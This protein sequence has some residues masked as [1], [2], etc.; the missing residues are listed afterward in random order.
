VLDNA[1]IDFTRTFYSHLF[2]GTP[3]C[4]AFKQAKGAVEFIY[5][6]TEASL[7]LMLLNEDLYGDETLDKTD[8]GHDCYSLPVSAPGVWKCHSEH[9]RIK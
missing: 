9:N 2:K 4:E 7:F 6:K 8:I 5:K 1:A 3:I